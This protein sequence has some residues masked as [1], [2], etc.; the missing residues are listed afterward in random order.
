MK[1]RPQGLR[2]FLEAKRLLTG[3]LHDILRGMTSSADRHRLPPIRRL[4][5][6]KGFPGEEENVSG[7]AESFSVSHSSSP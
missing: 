7:G 1:L 4:A 6:G 2:N 5:P 3:Y